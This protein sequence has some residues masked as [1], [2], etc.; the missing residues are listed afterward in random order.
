MTVNDQCL[1]LS[2][3]QCPH[4]QPFVFWSTAN[5]NWWFGDHSIQCT[6]LF[7]HLVSTQTKQPY[8]FTLKCLFRHYANSLWAFKTIL[9]SAG[10]WGWRHHILIFKQ[11]SG[12]YMK[13]SLTLLQVTRLC[14]LFPLMHVCVFESARAPHQCIHT[15]VR[16]CTYATP[17]PRCPHAS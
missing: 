10:E 4:L 13:C 6:V 8:S 2:C 11:G 16:V 7:G 1:S 17:C 9:S 14:H 5:Q 12:W 15:V 3:W